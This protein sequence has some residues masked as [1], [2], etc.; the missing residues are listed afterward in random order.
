MT[1]DYSLLVWAAFLFTAGVVC[2]LYTIAYRLFG[3]RGNDPGADS[4]TSRED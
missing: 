4:Y 3:T 1:A 2:I